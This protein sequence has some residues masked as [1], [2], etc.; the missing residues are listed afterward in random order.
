MK[1]EVVLSEGF[2][3]RKGPKVGDAIEQARLEFDVL[4]MKSG[5]G[6][7][8][9]DNIYEAFDAPNHPAIVFTLT[10]GK[11]TSV[12]GMQVTV[13]C[14]GTLKMAGQSH[15]ISLNLTG[16]QQEDGSYQFVG[17]H[18]LNMTQWGMEPPTA[19][20]GAIEAGEEVT[21]TFDLK[22]TEKE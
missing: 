3:K 10:Q 13:R 12:S 17:S 5:K 9:D 4:A 8:M 22:L 20:F 21:I 11:A 6:A 19:M 16:T 18:T 15:P 1:G 2:S 7:T 14:E